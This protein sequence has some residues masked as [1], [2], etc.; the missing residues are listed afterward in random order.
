SPELFR[1][2][3]SLFRL[4]VAQ[5]HD[6]EQAA[7]DDG[8]DEAAEHERVPD[9]VRLPGRDR[10]DP[11]DEQHDADA[12]QESHGA[13]DHALVPTG[14]NP[15]C[16]GDADEGAEYADDASADAADPRR[17]SAAPPR[18]QESPFGALVEFA[19]LA[20]DAR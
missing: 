3:A 15:A 16:R 6:G 12:G 11:G 9:V 4:A 2:E 10:R 5:P 17:V 7:D 20:R 18:H 14:G 19:P 13:E 8:H 1:A